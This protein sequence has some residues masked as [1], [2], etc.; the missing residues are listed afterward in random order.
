MREIPT[1]ARPRA[2]FTA[3]FGVAA[4]MLAGC[5]S[6]A[7]LARG[8]ETASF[9]PTSTAVERSAAELAENAELVASAAEV[10]VIPRGPRLVCRREI[11]IGSRIGHEVCT[12]E[13]GPDTA[14]D[15][16]ER[17]HTQYELEAN[18][19]DQLINLGGDDPISQPSD[20]QGQ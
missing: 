3:L 17:I 14:A 19:L 2:G 4:A 15:E 6:D 11:P 16:L 18:R 8:N 7:Q 1:A 10:P 5:A 9:A 13:G 12:M 20:Q